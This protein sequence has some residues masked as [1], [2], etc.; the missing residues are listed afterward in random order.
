MIQVGLSHALVNGFAR[1]KSVC[2]V[3]T[4]LDKSIQL[5]LG[6]CRIHA[7]PIPRG[8]ELLKAEEL[9]VRPEFVFSIMR[10]ESSF[11]PQARSPAN[12]YGLLQLIPANAIAVSGDVNIHFE[13]HRDKDGNL[14]LDNPE[15][16]YDPAINIPLGIALMKRLFKKNGD[17]FIK[18]TAGYNASPAAVETWIR[19]RYH[20]D[21][22]AFIDD[23]PFDETKIY[24]K[25]VMRNF[26]YYTRLQSPARDIEFPSWCLEGFSVVPQAASNRD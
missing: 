19:T 2:D 22:L 17:N 18:T 3:A 15:L 12:A 6:I 26:I 14:Q 1:V 24:I 13:T 10:Q 16:L 7:G 25:T 20:G 5:G 11:N 8:T 4:H 23:I 21:I 9:K